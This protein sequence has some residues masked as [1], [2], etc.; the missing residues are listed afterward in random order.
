MQVLVLGEAK[1]QILEFVDPL[2][3]FVDH[4]AQL[5]SQRCV[6]VYQDLF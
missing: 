6:L 1:R 5:V 3:H 2:I 4:F